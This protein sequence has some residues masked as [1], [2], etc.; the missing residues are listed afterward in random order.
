MTMCNAALAL[1]LCSLHSAQLCT[2]MSK[3][4]VGMRGASLWGCK[5]V[6][7]GPS[8]LGGLPQRRNCNAKLM[9]EVSTRV[10][11][12]MRAWVRVFLREAEPHLGPKPPQPDPQD[13]LEIATKI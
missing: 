6:Q 12:E 8:L 10:E 3:G 11:L 1:T 5:L 9:R 2:A 13:C 7:M 4:V